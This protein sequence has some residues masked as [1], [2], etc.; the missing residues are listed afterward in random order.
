ML[1][2]NINLLVEIFDVKEL[3]GDI[4]DGIPATYQIIYLTGWHPH[5]SQQKPSKRGSATVS[6]HEISKLQTTDLPNFQPLEELEDDIDESS[7]HE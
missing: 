5:S 4:N 1:C 7:K 2:D 6:M 3:F